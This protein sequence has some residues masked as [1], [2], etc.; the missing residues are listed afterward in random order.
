MAAEFALRKAMLKEAAQEVLVFRQGDHAIAHVP[1]RKD[2]QLFAQASGRAAVIG[3]GDNRRKLMDGA[4]P[5]G[6]RREG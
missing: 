6:I 2:V 4:G 3:D 5:L 1:R